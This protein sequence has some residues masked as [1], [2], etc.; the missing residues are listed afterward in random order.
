MNAKIPASG[1]NYITTLSTHHSYYHPQSRQ[2][3]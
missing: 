2:A 1:S 3:A